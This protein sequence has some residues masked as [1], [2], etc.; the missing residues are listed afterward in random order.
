MDWSPLAAAP[1]Y[2]TAA[3]A[4]KLVGVKTA[5]LIIRL[6]DQGMTSLEDVHFIGTTILLEL[7]SN[8]ALRK[9]IGKLVFN[10]GHSL[11]AHVG[12]FMGS[13]LGSGLV[14]RITGTAHIISIHVY[15]T[16]SHWSQ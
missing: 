10:S 6:I 1:W 2:D 11:G 13:H 12:G 14:G 3:A 15:C 4:T 7:Y 8:S 5:K 16:L 9:T